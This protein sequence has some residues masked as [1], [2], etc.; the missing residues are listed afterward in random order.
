MANLEDLRALAAKIAELTPENKV[1]LNMAKY[2]AF[3]SSFSDYVRSAEKEADAIF[4]A[5]G[6]KFKNQDEEAAAEQANAAETANAAEAALPQS[7]PL[8]LG[9]AAVALVKRFF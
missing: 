5:T 9:L 1:I 8:I 3:Y 6:Y 2:Y 4:A 7:F